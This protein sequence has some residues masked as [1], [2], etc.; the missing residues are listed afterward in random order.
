MVCFPLFALDYKKRAR[1]ILVGTIRF[2]VDSPIVES[3][4]ADTMKSKRLLP[5]EVCYILLE[6]F[7][8][9]LVD[10]VGNNFR[11]SIGSPKMLLKCEK[12]FFFHAP[13]KSYFMSKSI[14]ESDA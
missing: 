14:L 8:S 13:M 10:E 11:I 12:F 4:S 9:E 2:Y 1:S 7:R 5:K 6:S 3:S